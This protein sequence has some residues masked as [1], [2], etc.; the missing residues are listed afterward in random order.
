MRTTR[1]SAIAFV[2]A[3][4]ALPAAAAKPDPPRNVTVQYQGPNT[5]ADNDDAFISRIGAMAKPRP[6]ERFVDVAIADASGLPVSA[7][8]HQ[9]AR[10]LTGAF[11]G[12]T[13]KPVKLRGRAPLHVH[14]YAGPGCSGPSVPTKGTIT[15][16]FQRR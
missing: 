14:L 2:L 4:S 11:C 7:E 6:Q 5:V 1:A 10:D 16:S 3:V 13:E 15:F 8:L 12:E 9:G